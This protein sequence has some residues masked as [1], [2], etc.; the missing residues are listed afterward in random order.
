LPR[1]SNPVPATRFYWAQAVAA[2]RG[3]SWEAE[4]SWQELAIRYDEGVNGGEPLTAC[5]GWAG[6][7]PLHRDDVEAARA[8][9]EWLDLACGGSH[10]G[11]ARYHPGRPCGTV[12]GACAHAT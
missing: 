12:G 8:L 7:S 6:S 9:G 4:D 11:I 1:L 5:S 2:L 10:I 3:L